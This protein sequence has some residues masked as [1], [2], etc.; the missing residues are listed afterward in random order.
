VSRR[1][2]SVPATG[3]VAGR[4]ERRRVADLQPHPKAA[5]VPALAG[6]AYDAFG[7][8]VAARGLQVPL[9]VTHE[10]LVLDGRARLRAAREL[11]IE[12]VEVDVVAPRDELEHIVRA[13]LVRRQLSQ[14][15]RAALTL[16]LVPY[17]ALRAQA[18]ERKR[19]NLRRGPEAATLP[20]RGEPTSKLVADLAGTAQR[21][22]QD[23]MTVYEHDRALF[24]RVVRGE[25]GADTA[26]SK[27]RRARRDAQIQPPPPLPEGPFGLI[28]ADLPWASGSPDSQFAPEQHYPTMP[29]AEL[30]A[31]TVP[32][33]EDCVLFLWAVNC[34][35]L[36]AIE[37]CAAWGFRYR[38][39]LAW[40]KE[41]IGPGV[42]LRQRHELLL[43][44]TRGKLPPPEPEERCDSVI[45]APRGRH[46]EKPEEVYERIERMYPA[47]TKLELFARG[48]P[49]PGWTTWGNQAEQP[50]PQSSGQSAEPNIP[51]GGQEG[52]DVA[53]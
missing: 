33:A 16:L 52:G 19:A 38:N 20:A 42:W 2:D 13:A 29:L 9:E 30:K 12:E 53:E 27:V 11:G 10:G 14:S 41:S 39:N 34:L 50:E 8:D 18:D 51:A 26:A 37:L 43:I 4:R 17:E 5:V 44:A 1:P 15:Q 45:E 25:I 31:M 6:K 49:R 46:S 32:A 21:T 36:E 28:L 7:A 35:L 48:I 24:E 40:V 22:A 3:P 47:M 23:V